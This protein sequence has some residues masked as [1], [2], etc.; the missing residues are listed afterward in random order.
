MGLLGEMV[1]S[2]SGA[3]NGQDKPQTSSAW[4]Q[5]TYQTLE[6]YKKA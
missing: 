4:K 1:G 6:T 5:G 3:R 2:R